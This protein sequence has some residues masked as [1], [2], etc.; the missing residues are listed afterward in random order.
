ML[1]DDDICSICGALKLDD[2]ICPEDHFKE[3]QDDPDDGNW[4]HGNAS[5]MVGDE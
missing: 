2:G 3:R 4:I 5:G 1:D